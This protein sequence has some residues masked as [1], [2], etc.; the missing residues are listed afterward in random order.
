MSHVKR[1]TF[2]F[3]HKERPLIPVNFE[4]FDMSDEETCSDQ[5]FYIFFVYNFEFFD[6]FEIKLFSKSYNN[7]SNILL[8]VAVAPWEF[9]SILGAW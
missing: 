9:Y 7:F 5:D 8:F 6:H 2:D 1:G 4:I 3:T